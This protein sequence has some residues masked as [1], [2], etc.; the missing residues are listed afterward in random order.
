MTRQ[1]RT[2]N[3][4]RCVCFVFSQILWVSG[5]IRVQKPPRHTQQTR[6]KRGHLFDRDNTTGHDHH[7]AAVGEVTNSARLLQQERQPKSSR[8]SEVS[9]L[10]RAFCHHRLQPCKLIAHSHRHHT[11]NFFF[12]FGR[13]IGCQHTHTHKMCVF[14][15][16]TYTV[17]YLIR[18]TST[19]FNN[20][21][22]RKHETFDNTRR[23]RLANENRL[24]RLVAFPGLFSY[25]S[26][27]PLSF[28]LGGPPVYT[29]RRPYLA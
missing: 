8:R 7:T 19:L 23:R 18:A 5:F 6:R 29:T 22:G 28:P 11:R 26:A 21:R 17:R 9:D 13:E 20:P 2:I 16:I 25:Y 27:P 24:G 12:L 4:N 14:R 15:C 10:L 1:Q 3:T